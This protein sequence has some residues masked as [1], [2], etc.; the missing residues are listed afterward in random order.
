MCEM[1]NKLNKCLLEGLNSCI[2]E[3]E[4]LNWSKV[5]K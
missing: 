1:S 5:S 4:G 2:S 3:D